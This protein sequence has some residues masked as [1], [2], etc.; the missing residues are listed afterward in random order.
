MCQWPEFG[1]PEARIQVLFPVDAEARDLG[2]SSNAFPS[3]WQG[4]K[5]KREQSGV[6]QAEV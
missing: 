6:E 1:Q 3:H 2:Q 5:S 4:A